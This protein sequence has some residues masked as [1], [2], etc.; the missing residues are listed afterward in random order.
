MTVLV[1]SILLCVAVLIT[2]KTK[3]DYN[4]NIDGNSHK[5]AKFSDRDTYFVPMVVII[6]CMFP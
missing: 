5:S 3:A 2:G 6:Y 4:I 1:I